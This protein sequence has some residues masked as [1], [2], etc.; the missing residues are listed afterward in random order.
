MLPS[1]I[2]NKYK[3]IFNDYAKDKEGMFPEDASDIY[4]LSPTACIIW[5]SYHGIRRTLFLVLYTRKWNLLF[6]ISKKQL[7]RRFLTIE[8]EMQKY[9][10]L[11]DTLSDVP[12]IMLD[13]IKKLER[14][15]KNWKRKSGQG[16]SRCERRDTN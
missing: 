10:P 2:A 4:E 5:S 15:N 3:I 16:V 11:I 8:K 6:R 9:E 12:S 1:R 7:I 14:R 13:Q